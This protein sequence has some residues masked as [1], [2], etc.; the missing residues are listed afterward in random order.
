MGSKNPH[1]NQHNPQ[2]ANYWALLTRKRHH[3]AHRL[4]GPSESTDPTQHAKGRTGDCRGPRK[5]TAT[6]RNVTQG[7]WSG[8]KS[9]VENHMQRS[10]TFRALGGGRDALEWES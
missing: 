2:C 4:Q 1:N 9:S 10:V 7:L 8:R 3:K 6:R 5:E